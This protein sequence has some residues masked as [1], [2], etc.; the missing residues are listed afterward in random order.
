MAKE[1]KVF[2]FTEQGDYLMFPV[3]EQEVIPFWSSHSRMEAVQ[4]MHPK[5]VQFE[6]SEMS[7]DEFMK[8][9]PEL[10]KDGIHIGVNWAGKRLIGYDVAAPQLQAGI[11]YWLNREPTT[12][13]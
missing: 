2:T 3:G 6:I 8:W 10:E 13:G 12:D 1:G 9:L 5:Y 11:E 4:K 7:L